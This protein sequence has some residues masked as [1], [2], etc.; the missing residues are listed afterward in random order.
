ME[1]IEGTEI[2]LNI[3]DQLIYEKEPRIYNGKI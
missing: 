3:G 2:N 1:R